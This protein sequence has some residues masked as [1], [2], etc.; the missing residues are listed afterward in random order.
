[1]L[2]QII[3]SY[4]QERVDLHE[5]NPCLTTVMEQTSRA[6]ND[7][8]QIIGELTISDKG[9]PT[10]NYLTFVLTNGPIMIA[11]N[12]GMPLFYST[13]KKLCPERESCA[14]FAPWCEALP[15]TQGDVNHLIFSSEPL[16]GE[17]IWLTTNFGQMVGVDYKMQLIS[18]KMILPV[19]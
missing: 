15:S 16:Q 13:H 17:N 10:E 2:F 19:T 18:E 9:V 12:G 1:M 3:L 14:S 11:L 4:L 6:I 7:I 5:Q 8:C